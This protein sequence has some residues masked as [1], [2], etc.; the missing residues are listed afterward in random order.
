M[1]KVLTDV[2]V[3][4][5][6]R[7]GIQ[8]P[9]TV[10]SEAEAGVLLGRLEASEANHGGRLPPR[11]NQKPHL[12]HP[13]MNELV[14]HPL[15]LDAVEDVLGPNLLCW[16]AQF[17]AKNA[18]DPSYVSWHQ[19]GTYWGLSSPDVVTAWV[20]LTPS[21]PENGCMQVVP[22]THRAQ[23]EH[24]DTFADANLLS[25]GQEIRVEVRP[26]DVVP[27]ILRPGQMSLHHVLIFHGSEPNTADYRRVGFAIRYI[28]T[29]VRQVNAPRES[30]TLVRGVDRYGYFD[31]ESPPESD[32]HPDA[33]ARH[34]AI[35]DRQLKILYAGAVKP[36]KLGA[37]ISS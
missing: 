35:V 2:Q 5:F 14:R 9:V 36:G 31:L 27:V 26:D 10:M 8:F 30:A 19:D 23:V 21:V 29:H 24:V 25:R 16:S 11:I 13:W 1:G 7:D 20:A 15:I 18:R 34:A 12:L 28:P 17:F 32:M 33:V 4:A 22:G 3:D 6:R 37:D